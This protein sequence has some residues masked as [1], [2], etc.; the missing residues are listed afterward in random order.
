M[1]QISEFSF[2][3]PDSHLEQILLILILHLPLANTCTFVPCHLCNHLNLIWCLCFLVSLCLILDALVHFFLQDSLYLQCYQTHPFK[4]LLYSSIFI[5]R[6][7][8]GNISNTYSAKLWEIPFYIF[9]CCWSRKASNEDFLC[10]RH[11]LKW[12]K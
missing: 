9:Y 7:F 6:V 10:F 5:L 3:F 2:R 8:F 12:Q 4:I 1:S 11:H